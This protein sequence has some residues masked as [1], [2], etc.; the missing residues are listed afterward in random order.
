MQKIA[1]AAFSAIAAF[2]ALTTTASA[3]DAGKCGVFRY[4]NE[5][6]GACL[7]ARNAPGNRAVI[8]EQERPVVV[9]DNGYATVVRPVDITR[10]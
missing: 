1:L 10:Y 4:Y 3:A 9:M 8:I 7:D 6:V 5:D 2:G